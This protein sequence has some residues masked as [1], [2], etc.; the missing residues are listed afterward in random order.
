MRRLPGKR[1]APEYDFALRGASGKPLPAQRAGTKRR[2]YI[3]KKLGVDGRKLAK[4][5][6][7]MVSIWA[8][9]EMLLGAI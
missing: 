1:K 2:R 9:M 4:G 8:K 7:P 5:K 6:K 3:R